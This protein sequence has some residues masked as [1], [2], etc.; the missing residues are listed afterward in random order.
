M[1][2]ARSTLRSLS[3]LNT[4]MCLKKKKSPIAAIIEN[5]GIR[6]TANLLFA[7]FIASATSANV[8]IPGDKCL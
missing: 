3:G 8:N 1:F 4:C 6:R 5:R 7:T 2:N